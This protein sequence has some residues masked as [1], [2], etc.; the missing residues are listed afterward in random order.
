M[1]SD[2]EASQLI[3][4]VAQRFYLLGQSK[5]EIADELGLSRFRVARMLKQAREQ[6]IVTIH[7]SA[8]PGEHH[9]L[10]NQL[11]KHL[12]LANTVIV[13]SKPTIEQEREDLARGASEYLRLNVRPG[14]VIGLSWGRTLLPVAGYLHDLP[15]LTFVQ[16]T[17]VVGSDASKSPI[18]IISRIRQHS[19]VEA[20][21]LLAPLFA[22]SPESAMAL[23]QEPAVAE[24]FELYGHLDIAVLSVGSWE[25]R[26]TQLDQLFDRST[27]EELDRLR[28]V[29]DFGGLFFDAEGR[30]IQ[31]PLN[32][33]RLSISAEDLARTPIVMAVAG[34]LLKAPAIHATCMTGLVTCLVTSKR[35]AEALLEMPPITHTVWDRRSSLQDSSPLS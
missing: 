5:V 12:G 8:L 15:P 6:G 34:E 22:I 11:A 26:L 13:G 10:E 23:R 27:C 17:G 2:H 31:T 30:Y 18:E 24:A 14:Q 9:A 25:P 1:Q 21:S 20:R 7:V 33:R 3:V 32:D 16:L 28:A 35:V 4:D 29:A 19:Q